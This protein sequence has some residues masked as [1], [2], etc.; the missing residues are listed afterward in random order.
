MAKFA[1]IHKVVRKVVVAKNKLEIPT[2]ARAVG[3]DKLSP[4]EK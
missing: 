2:S 4:V 1:A 3:N